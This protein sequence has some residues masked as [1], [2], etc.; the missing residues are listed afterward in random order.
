MAAFGGASTF[1]Q[2]FNAGTAADGEDPFIE[3]PQM[4]T[5]DN[6][7]L[8][9]QM[10]RRLLMDDLANCGVVADTHLN[11]DDLSVKLQKSKRSYN[12][13]VVR[14]VY[15]SLASY[16]SS[17]GADFVTGKQFIEAYMK[18]KREIH[19]VLDNTSRE[20]EMVDKMLQQSQA[21]LTKYSAQELTQQQQMNDESKL[22]VQ[23]V[24]V[25][26]IVDGG[27]D[28]SCMYKIHLECQNQ[29][30]DTRPVYQSSGIAY[31]NEMFSF[32]ISSRQGDLR[33]KFMQVET[34]SGAETPLGECSIMVD[35]LADQRK[36]ELTKEIWGAQRADLL[37]SCQWI[38]SKKVLYQQYLREFSSKREQK[39]R[40]L[41][42]YQNEYDKLN[43]PFSSEAGLSGSLG[44]LDAGPEYVSRAIEQVM[45]N[46]K[47]TNWQIAS[48]YV[49]TITFVL[50]CIASYTRCLFFDQ[51]I[52]AFAFWCNLDI[53]RWSVS[54]YTSVVLLFML[55]I[56]LD[57]WWMG[58][59]FKAWT[60]NSTESDFHGV[61]KVFSFFLCAWKMVV[62]LFFWKCGYDM[63]K[64]S[65]YQDRLTHAQ[66]IT[67]QT[68]VQE[69][70]QARIERM[71][72]QPSYS[73]LSHQPQ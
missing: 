33:V 43:Q 61:S 14:R 25:Q 52:S 70:Q 51:V 56:F 39:L 20:L 24:S 13:E 9:E 62:I 18:R 66:T 45:H 49:V 3:P 48:Q 10:E 72:A 63:K 21:S 30:I 44:V 36:H 37:L 12:D 31:F 1:F 50:V 73:L 23:V 68:D 17:L 15:A 67:R 16:Q 11:V 60:L 53:R 34:Y 64:K 4:G 28:T 57:F 29:V 22:T 55:S 7:E 54:K 71:D 27:N 35:D 32:Q 19:S 2:P 5:L 69:R 8:Q 38:Y 65:S 26:N 46:M 40:D 58:V 47:L 42:E 6:R 41:A 59:Y